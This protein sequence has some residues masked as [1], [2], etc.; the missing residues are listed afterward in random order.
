M[1][2]SPDAW[3]ALTGVAELPVRHFSNSILIGPDTPFAFLGD[4]FDLAAPA[5]A[6]ERLLHRRRRHRLRCCR[7]PRREHATPR[8][9]W[10]AARPWA[11]LP[12]T[13]RG[14]GLW[15]RSRWAGPGSPGPTGAGR[16]RRPWG[17]SVRRSRR[18]RQECRGHRPGRGRTAPRRS[19]SRP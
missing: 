9:P 2:S 16:G 19:D 15:S 10:T 11:T 7:V 12:R 14:G 18:R 6:R 1:P 3:L 17:P 13:D 8:R 5:A 4:V